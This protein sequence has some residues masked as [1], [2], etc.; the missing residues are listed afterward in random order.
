[1]DVCVMTQHDAASDLSTCALSLARLRLSNPPTAAR[2]VPNNN[3]VAGSGTAAGGGVGDTEG[4][5]VGVGS[6]VVGG[7]SSDPT[8]KNKGMAA[9]NS[10]GHFGK[11]PAR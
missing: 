1:M 6:G 9:R 8:M 3:N 5:G 2:L 10:K 7:V 4:T 11:P